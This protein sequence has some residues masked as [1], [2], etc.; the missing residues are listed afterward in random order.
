MERVDGDDSRS[1]FA[2]AGRLAL[3]PAR[4]AARASRNQFEAA[5]DDHLLPELSRLADRALAGELPEQLANSIVEHH[6]LERVAT[7][8]AAGSALDA[9]L[10][11]ALASPRTTELT[12]RL[13]R[14]EEMQRA[15]RA[16]VSSPEIRAA[17]AEQS[18]GVV[19]ELARDIRRKCRVLDG[20]I[21]ERLRRH[22]PGAASGWAGIATRAVAFAT[23]LLAIAAIF[24]L[25][26]GLLA[27]ISY[28]VGGLRPVWLV[29]ALLGSGWALVGST[30]LTLF[31]GGAGRTPGMRL[32]RIR[33]RDQHAQSPSFAR[34][35]LRTIVTWVSIVPF[36][37][38]YVPVLFDARRRG[39]PDL[40]A[41]TE[42][43]YDDG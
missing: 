36:F 32:M 24:A 13:V 20:R 11:K 28:L 29:E 5:T 22:A 12:E 3:S 7:E 16:I 35:F 37:L 31:W 43:V 1:R 25:G 10:E 19:E 2:A 15:L 23:D 8:L 40:A 39:L 42:V 18:M 6:V 4:A 27:L 33:V 14:S 17:L 21:A 38:G 34:A 41:R 30:Y 26:A 9:A